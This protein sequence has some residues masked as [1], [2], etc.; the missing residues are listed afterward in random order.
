MNLAPYPIAQLDL[1][2]EL[3]LADFEPETSGIFLYAIIYVILAH[4][5]L[6]AK[7]LLFTN[8]RLSSTLLL[9][10]LAVIQDRETHNFRILFFI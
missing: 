2:E 5:F 1:N 8:V 4:I 6:V 10:V 9:N 3:L 7:L